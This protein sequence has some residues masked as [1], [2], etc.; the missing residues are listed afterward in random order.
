MLGENQVDAGASSGGFAAF[1]Q[2]RAKGSRACRMSQGQPQKKSQ[3]EDC[4]F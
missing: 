2:P 4:K 1:G 3:Y